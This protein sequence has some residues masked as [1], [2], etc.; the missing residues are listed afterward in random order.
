ML[1]PASVSTPAEFNKAREWKEGRSLY[2]CSV[3]PKPELLD[4]FSSCIALGIY[5]KGLH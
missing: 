5:Q 1:S 3:I 4:L 2:S